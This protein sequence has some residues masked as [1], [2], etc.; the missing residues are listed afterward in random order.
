MFFVRIALGQPI[1]GPE[2]A[3]DRRGLLVAWVAV[4]VRRWLDDRLL[5]NV[6][7]LVI[8]PT[9]FLLAEAARPRERPSSYMGRS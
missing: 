6:A 1:G 9:E 8:P 2:A 4:Q 7:T 3:A 5:G